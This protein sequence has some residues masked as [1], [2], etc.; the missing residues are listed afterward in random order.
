MTRGK[1]RVRKILAELDT[2]CTEMR[3][4]MWAGRPDYKVAFLKSLVEMPGN[5]ILKSPG[6]NLSPLAQVAKNM[7]LHTN[8]PSRWHGSPRLALRAL[9]MQPGVVSFLEYM[10]RDPGGQLD[11]MK[12]LCLLSKIPTTMQ[13]SFITST[14]CGVIKLVVLAA[15]DT[16]YAVSVGSTFNS[17]FRVWASNGLSSTNKLDVYEKV[18]PWFR[19]PRGDLQLDLLWSGLDFFDRTVLESLAQPAVFEHTG[20]LIVFL[21]FCPRQQSGPLQA[22]GY[23]WVSQA[24]SQVESYY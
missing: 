9:G 7:C 17:R 14:V 20:K 4:F 19:A 13:Q 6:S 24:E 21:P 18:R 12:L 8:V 3:E 1:P 2:A 23:M 22:S 16:A 11:N 15:F 10:A 5:H